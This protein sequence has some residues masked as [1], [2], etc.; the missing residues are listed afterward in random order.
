MAFTNKEALS[1]IKRHKITK[2]QFFEVTTTLRK[3]LSDDLK[4]MQ[5]ELPPL[6]LREIKAKFKDAVGKTYQEKMDNFFNRSITK[7]EQAI[8]DDPATTAAVK[9][10]IKVDVKKRKDEEDEA[11]PSLHTKEQEDLSRPIQEANLSQPTFKQKQLTEK[12]G[13]ALTELKTALKG[14]LGEKYGDVAGKGAASAIDAYKRYQAG[15]FQAPEE[16]PFGGGSDS[17]LIRN[18]DKFVNTVRPG[19]SG[20]QKN[21]AMAAPLLQGAGGLVGKIGG[22]LLGSKMGLPLGGVAAGGEL[23]SQVTQKGLE[24]LLKPRG[25]FSNIGDVIRGGKPGMIESARRGLGNII[26]GEGQGFGDRY[27]R[28]FGEQGRFQSLRRGLGDLVGG[29]QE[30]LF[31][32]KGLAQAISDP[33]LPM[34]LRSGLEIGHA[35]YSIGDSLGLN[36]YIARAGNSLLKKIGLA[37][38][39]GVNASG[40]ESGSD[41]ASEVTGGVISRNMPY[42]QQRAEKFLGHKVGPGSFG[43]KRLREQLEAESIPAVAKYDI[44]RAQLGR[45][46]QAAKLKR[47]AIRA[48]A[49]IA[50]REQQFTNLAQQK[51]FEEQVRGE[52][53]NQQRDLLQAQ[54][55]AENQALNTRGIGLRQKM[56]VNPPVYRQGAV[57]TPVSDAFGQV[58][59]QAFRMGAKSLLRN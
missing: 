39:Y 9:T 51:R 24:A 20:A 14:K 4:V 31:S 18:Y 40:S 16:K 57:P 23:G 48:D 53:L 54:M 19:R 38:E 7:S 37:S 34:Q 33:K 47:E 13:P 36:K 44:T 21:L 43:E 2:D 22:G 59:G 12:G 28:Q 45:K 27:N 29:G 55:D 1:F 10:K 6:V 25:E 41:L 46:K 26:S 30:S 35:L 17:D 42:M 32:R 15:E 56:T 49:D 8:L 50:G 58:G 11:Q 52:Q 3:Y 5:D